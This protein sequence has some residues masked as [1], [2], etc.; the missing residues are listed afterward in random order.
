MGSDL[1]GTFNPKEK[2]TLQGYFDIYLSKLLQFMIDGIV[3][4]TTEMMD[5]LI[6]P[7]KAIVLPNG[8][9]FDI[10]KKHSK[11]EAKQ[12][13]RLDPNK[14]YILFAGNYLSPQKGYSILAKAVNRLK[15]NRPEYELLLAH[16]VPHEIVPLYMNA[17]E[18]LGLPSLKEGSP[19]V[20]K[21]AIACNL[22]VV[23]TDVGDIRKTI[24]DIPGCFLVERNAD[25][26]VSAL[27]KAAQANSAFRGRSYIDHL[28]IERIAY[29]LRCYY[30]HLLKIKGFRGA[31]QCSV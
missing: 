14:K 16:N 28:R 13:L 6:A 15:Q 10:F 24:G 22:P 8:V 12:K 31:R 29:Q 26:F 30:T 2:I 20:V 21:E 3:V 7:Q 1:S 27:H 19:N 25:R 18:V 23:A 4:K 9:D 11:E 5:I 17:A